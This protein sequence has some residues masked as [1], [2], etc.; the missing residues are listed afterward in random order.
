MP[1]VFNL[2]RLCVSECASLCGLDQQLNSSRI[3][4]LREEHE[5]RYMVMG[6]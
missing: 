5:A 1:I 4:P 3:L 2:Q 6:P